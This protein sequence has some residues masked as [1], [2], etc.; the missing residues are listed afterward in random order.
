MATKLSDLQGT[1]IWKIKRHPYLENYVV[2]YGIT[3]KK[4]MTI[5][6]DAWDWVV[7]DGDGNL[8]VDDIKGEVDGK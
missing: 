3:G 1:V 7:H 8:L 6:T 2:V 5:C 4:L